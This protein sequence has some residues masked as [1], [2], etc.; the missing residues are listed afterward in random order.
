M[1]PIF[2]QSSLQ[3]YLDCPRR[4]QLRYIDRLRWPAAESEP[5]LENE[6]HV[7]AGSAFHRLAQQ[8]LIGLPTDRLV[9]FAQGGD[10]SRWWDH[11]TS[12]F[13]PLDQKSLRGAKLY[14]E[15]TLSTRILD[16]RITAKYDLIAVFDDR[17][18]IYDWK[19]YHKR[20]RNEF[21]STRMQTRVYPALLMHAGAHL[22]HEKIFAPEQIEMIYWFTDFPQDPAHFKYNAETFRR[23]WSALE[24]TIQEISS[25][26]P[27]AL[28]DETAKC[29]F[30]PYRSYCKRDVQAGD[31]RDAEDEAEGF[32]FDFDAVAEIPLE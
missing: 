5:A 14:P 27:F 29:K 22:H 6:K 25:G 28:T 12:A 10:L 20:T 19:T 21:L 15:V 18:I 3:D 7:Q 30:C 13:F 16:Q 2:S 23:D 8:A 24:K 26:T 17:A 1:L 11:F 4:F 31:W 32:A 9:S